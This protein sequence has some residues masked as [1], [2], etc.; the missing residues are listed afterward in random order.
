MRAG[1]LSISPTRL[2]LR[3]EPPIPRPAPQSLKTAIGEANLKRFINFVL[4]YVADLATSPVPHPSSP[5]SSPFLPP[6]TSCS[7]APSLC[8]LSD[9]L[10]LSCVRRTSL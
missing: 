6:R 2:R 3:C 8:T 9:R 7:T 4:R 10:S 5:P 1:S